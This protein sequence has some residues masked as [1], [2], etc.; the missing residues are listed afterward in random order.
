MSGVTSV[1]AG[2]VYLPLLRACCFQYRYIPSRKVDNKLV[3]ILLKAAKNGH[4][5][6]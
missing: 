1:C 3:T 6:C 4:R 5:C 2:G